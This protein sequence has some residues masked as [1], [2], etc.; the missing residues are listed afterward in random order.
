M[1]LGMQLFHAL[2]RHVR[3]DLRGR[4]VAVP[5][6]HLHHTQVRA[7]IEQVGREGVAQCVGR[8]IMAD[9]RLAGVAFDDVPE[10]LA[11][12]AIARRV[13]NR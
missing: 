5:E 8:E 7:V 12:H 2:A 4:Q 11:G 6:Q 9:T 13:G 10:S 3:V 1:M